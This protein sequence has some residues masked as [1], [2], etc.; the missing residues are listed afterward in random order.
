MDLV[1]EFSKH[2]ATS[3]MTTHRLFFSI[4]RIKIMR[5][6]HSENIA[7]NLVLQTFAVT[8]SKSTVSTLWNVLIN[9]IFW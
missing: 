9:L 5:D 1:C 4:F 7:Q 2:C 6:Y 8:C 3:L